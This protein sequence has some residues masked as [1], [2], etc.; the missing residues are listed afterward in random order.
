MANPST[1]GPSGVG[2]EVLRRSHRF[3]IANS[4]EFLLQGA[5]NHIYTVL[6]VIFCEQD[7]HT[8]TTL[9]MRVDIENGGS[10]QLVLLSN[11]S[12]GA[13]GTFIWNDKFVLTETDEL[14]VY[15]SGAGDD[16]HVWCTYIDQQFA[17]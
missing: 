10:N 17:A 3:S 8:D 11:Q 15:T 14:G 9:T 6:S 1:T 4:E 5:A 16:V 7:G 12:I 2:T 13:Y